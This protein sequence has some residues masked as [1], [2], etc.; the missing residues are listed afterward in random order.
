MEVV[1]SVAISKVKTSKYWDHDQRQPSTI[2]FPVHIKKWIGASLG[3]P[4]V[5][6]LPRNVG[7]TG[8]IPGE[9]HVL[10]DK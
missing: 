10:R 2:V 9:S 4:G 5:K 8:L 3:G 7:D 1:P 6:N